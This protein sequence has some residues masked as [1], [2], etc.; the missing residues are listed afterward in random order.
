MIQP[1]GNIKVMDFGIARAKNSMMSKTSAVL[2]T[3]HYIS[4]EQAQGK[5]LTTASDIYSLGVVLYE[6]ATG[7]LPFDGP[8]SV[9]VAMKQVSEDPIPPSQVNPD[10]DPSLES[11]IMRAM[12]KDPRDRFATVGDMKHA[13]NDFLAGK[14]VRV[15]NEPTTLIP[16]YEYEPGYDNGYTEAYPNNYPDDTTVMNAVPAGGAIPASA[17]Q[18]TLV[19]EGAQEAARRKRRR[20][21][22]VALLLLALVAA[23][24]AGAWAWM[25]RTGVVPDV[26]GRTVDNAVV[27]L[28]DAGFALGNQT[29]EYSSS[30]E[31][32]KVISTDPAAGVSASPGTRINL[33]VSKGR[34]QVEVPNLVGMSGDEAKQAL[35]GAGLKGTEGTAQHSDSVPANQVIS[36][37]PEAGQQVDRGGT[38]TYVLSLGA[39]AFEV[40]DVVRQGEGAATATLS[41]AGFLVEVSYQNDNEVE[42]GLVISQTPHAGE[43]LPKGATVSIVVSAGAETHS[44]SALIVDNTGAV[45]DGAAVTFNSE[46]VNHGGADSFWVTV[47]DDYELVSIVDSNGHDYG[48]STSG[49][50]TEINHDVQ[51]IVTVREKPEPEP[52]PTPTPTPTPS[53]SQEPSSSTTDKDTN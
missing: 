50:I 53:S 17:M 32:G 34:D 36:Q 8:D 31:A 19:A 4:P 3:A 15:N 44:V 27:L 20:G 5:D 37:N 35:E 30:V 29:E 18:R 25:H 33:V 21:W 6:A 16:N 45:T 43:K 24:A 28:E 49:T 48:G 39:E 12:Q 46:T 26:S 40:P 23:G 13:L 10:V 9:S 1:D 41:N 22:I 42:Q 7:A 11:I 14:V 51:L 47:R 38:V 52:T 2:G